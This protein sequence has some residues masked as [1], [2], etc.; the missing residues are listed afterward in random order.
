MRFQQT[1]RTPYLNRGDQKR[2]LVLVGMIAMIVFSIE[3][4]ARP[5]SWYWLTGRPADAEP[6]SDAK[7]ETPRPVEKIDFRP[8]MKDSTLGPQVIRVVGGHTPADADR[9]KRGSESSESANSEEHELKLAPELVELIRDNAVG[10]RESERELYYYLLAKTRDVPAKTLE[11]ASRPSI[12]FA[13]LMNES[14]NRL[15]EII[16]VKGE[17]RRLAAIP[18]GK[19][20]FGIETIWEGWLFNAD[21]G[22]NPFCI[23][24]TSVPEGIPMGQDLGSGVIVKVTGYFLK[25]YGYPAQQDRLHVAPLILAKSVQWYEKRPSSVP[26]DFG[27]VPYVLGFAGILGVIISILLYRFRSSDREFE[28]KHLRRL[29]AAPAGAIAAISDLPTFEL[30]DS[31]R[32]LAAEHASSIEIVDAESNNDDNAEKHNAGEA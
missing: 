13:V 30:E 10:I 18:A 23:R 25:R 4:A 19:N 32:Q 5:S 31:L 22:L 8:D 12:A 1:N 14:K 21:S 9:Y 29:T 7:K 28:K 27:I 11:S 3:F 2:L 16:T 20:E 17:L 15:G 26:D 24:M 6:V